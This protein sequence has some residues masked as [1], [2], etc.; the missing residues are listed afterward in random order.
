M[1]DDPEIYRTVLLELSAGVYFVDREQKIVFWNHGA[2]NIT[3][4]LSQH[5][6]G[7]KMAEN[8][9][10]HVNGENQRLEG[11]ELPL[12][13][14]LRHGKKIEARLTVRHK[15]GHPVRLRV[16]KPAEPAQ[17]KSPE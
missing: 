8:F 1:L 12:N 15:E 5:V 9:L 6:L 4:Y 7:H 2:E 13:A 14:A 16:A 17:K 3:G 11:D 10:E